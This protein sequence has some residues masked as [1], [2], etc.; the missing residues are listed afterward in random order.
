MSLDPMSEKAESDYFEF[1]LYVYDSWATF[2]DGVMASVPES[3]PVPQASSDGLSGIAHY[4]TA[5][6]NLKVAYQ[7]LAAADE[8]VPGIVEAAASISTAGQQDIEANVDAINGF[9][10][11]NPSDLNQLAQVGLEGVV[12]ALSADEY[13]ARLSDAYLKIISGTMTTATQELQA[14]A[15]EVD[16]LA[17]ENTEGE[18]TEG[19]NT[20][21]ENTE[22]ENTEG[23]NTEG[24]NTGWENT[25]WENTEWENTEWENTDGTVNPDDGT[26]RFQPIDFGADNATEG[27]AE[28]PA[29]TT[30]ETEQ[31]GAS[32]TS[33]ESAGTGSA[34]DATPSSVTPAAPQTQSMPSTS[35][36]AGPGSLAQG[37]APL[38]NARNNPALNR[39]Q[40]DQRYDRSP[41]ERGGRPVAPTAPPPAQAQNTAQP[42]TTSTPNS[43]TTTPARNQVSSSQPLRTPGAEDRMVYTFRD[44]RTQ[45]VSPVV[46]AALTAA[47]DNAARTDARAAYS[48]TTAKI[49]GRQLGDRVDPNQVVTGDIAEWDQRTALVV[50]F[51]TETS[52]TLEVIVDGQLVPFTAELSDSQGAFGAFSGFFH[53]RGIDSTGPDHAAAPSDPA[54][55]SV[56]AAIP[57]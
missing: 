48:K 22:G 50:A 54:E 3:A 10:K 28:N 47:S 11:V 15:S 53:P 40:Q 49:A 41:R 32:E 35:S 45:E 29:A 1:A 56:S 42:S 19:G 52:G 51:G 2:G 7:E 36:G 25:G 6:H 5:V 43:P 26:T 30:R 34:V 21:G 16:T 44:G 18:N 13:L 27:T 17:P 9:V 14:I 33:G 12:G 20:E 24:E 37:L 4:E 57:A 38:M 46:Y 8:I 55:V 23:E 39:T 31:R